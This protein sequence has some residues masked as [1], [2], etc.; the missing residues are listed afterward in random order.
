M[1]HPRT[2]RPTASGRTITDP[3]IDRLAAAAEAGYDV[4]A[5]ITRRGKRGRPTLG[6]AAASVESV[7]LDPE[8]LA[9]LLQRARSE[10]VVRKLVEL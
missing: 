1:T 7:R 9:Q 6:T 2:P 8:L 5:L 10:E 3:E 4:D